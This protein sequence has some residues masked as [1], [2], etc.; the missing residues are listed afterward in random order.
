M[1]FQIDTMMIDRSSTL[2]ESDLGKF[3][4][5]VNGAICG[6]CETRQEAESLYGSFIST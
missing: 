5:L 2:E 6:F 3:C 4:F 1:I